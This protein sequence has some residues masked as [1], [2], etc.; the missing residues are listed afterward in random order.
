MARRTS[1]LSAGK[2]VHNCAKMAQG[3]ASIGGTAAAGA[4]RSSQMRGNN[5]R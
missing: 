1:S 2:R 4:A 5:R 3:E